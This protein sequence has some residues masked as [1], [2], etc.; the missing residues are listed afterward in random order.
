VDRGTAGDF[1][2]ARSII[3][4]ELEG[5]VPWYYVPGNH[6]ANGGHGLAEFQAA[7]GDTHRVVDVHGIRLVL[8]D[9]SRGTVRGG[10]FDQVRMLREALDSAKN[11]PAVRGV[12]VAMHHPVKDPSPTG[13][14]QLAD[15]KE[16]SLLSTWLTGFELASGK[17]AAAIASHAGVFSVSRVDGVPYLINGNSGKTP[18][19]APGDGGFTGWT[20]VRFD[21]ADPAQPVRFET[22]PNV[23][24]LTLTGPAELTTGAKADVRAV[25]TQAGRQ[26][27]VSYPVSADWTGAWG[28]RV[29]EGPTWPAP[30]EVASYDPST[31]VLTALRPGTAQLTVSVNGVSRTLAVTVR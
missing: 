27:P 9:S 2:L 22:R 7:F 16:A 23:D 13:G 25:L 17:P 24:A 19:A 10:G 3:G 11:D 30:W 14:S 12:A 8:L 28:T 4:D 20:L 21:P 26:V 29:V 5:K 6:E 31:G 18:A 1:V 15:R